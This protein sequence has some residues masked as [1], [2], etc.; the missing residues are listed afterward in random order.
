[1]S[2]DNQQENATPEYKTRSQ[3]G[4][5]A[6]KVVYTGVFTA[7]YFVIFFAIGML[8]FFGP[9]F[10]LVSGP[11]AFLIEGTIIILMLNKIKS[12]GALTALG[13][14]IGLLM[15]L[16]GHSWTT[17]LFTTVMAFLGDLLAWTGR[18]VNRGRIFSLMLFCSCGTSARGS[19]FSTLPTLISLISPARWGKNM[20]T[21]CR[22][23]LLRR[24]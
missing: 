20:Q 24:S 17:L 4:V 9:Q 21:R 3:S 11:L 2:I 15:L 8:G 18:Y 7:I 16:T 19:Q 14:I 23:S 10:M 12:F 22:L 6:H 5:S 1:M 13:I